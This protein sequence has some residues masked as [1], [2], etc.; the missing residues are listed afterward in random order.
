MEVCVERKSGSGSELNDWLEVE[1]REIPSIKPE[2]AEA[3]ADLGGWGCGSTVLAWVMGEADKTGLDRCESAV[4]F[5]E[6]T[7]RGSRLMLCLLA[8]AYARQIYDPEEIVRACRTDAVL[9]RFC[10]GVVPFAAEVAWFRRRN[11]AVLERVLAGVLLR[12]VRHRFDLNGVVLPTELTDDLRKMAI[13]RLNIARH[14][15]KLEVC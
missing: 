1:W 11:R 8:Y 4:S 14:M 3:P 2:E 13:D 10:R 12:A 6:S 15:D 7:A 9:Q 5:Q